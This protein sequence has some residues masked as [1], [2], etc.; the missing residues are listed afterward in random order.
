M[1]FAV[2]F[3]LPAVTMTAQEAPAAFLRGLGSY[4]EAYTKR[5]RDYVARESR[6]QKHW[7]RKLRLEQRTT[8]SDYYVVSLPSEPGQ[9]VEFRDTLF[10]NGKPVSR[11]QGEVLKTL[12]KKGSGM[13]AEVRRFIKESKRYDLGVLKRVEEYTNMGLLY[14]HPQAQPHIRYEL[15]PD[16]PTTVRFRES[17]EDTI[18]KWDGR[19]APGTGVITFT[20]PDYA[21]VR[22]DLV[23]HYDSA[24]GPPLLR[25]ITDYEPGAEGLMLPSH[26]RLFLPERFE[27]AAPETWES[28]AR[29]SDYRR[30]TADVKIT[31]EQ[32]R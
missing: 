12:T 18:A 1:R 11:R 24:D 25:C 9:L 31:S 14:V 26:T 5:F 22:V 30:F 17:P 19:P 32:P 15:L 27:H 6:I 8:V 16:N 10:V 13:E 21:I 2:A 4:S 29:Y 3:L 23:M 20:R 7:D 28:E